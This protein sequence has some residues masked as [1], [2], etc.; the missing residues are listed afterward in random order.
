MKFHVSFRECSLHE[1]T[2]IQ[3][4]MTLVIRGCHLNLSVSGFFGMIDN[5][6]KL[7]V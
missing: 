4:A 2:S 1:G 3:A 5:G 7:L 6:S